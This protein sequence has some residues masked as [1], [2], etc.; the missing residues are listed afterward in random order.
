MSLFW[1]DSVALCCSNVE[2][3]KTWW[4]HT[5]DCKA[6]KVPETWDC[7]LPSDVALKLPGALDDPTILLCDKAEVQKAGYERPND[8]T[9]LFCR[10]IEKAMT[11]WT[12]RARRL[13]QS[14]TPEERG[15]LIFAILKATSSRSA[16]SRSPLEAYDR[17]RLTPCFIGCN[18]RP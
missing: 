8:H 15:T 13:D 3:E 7:P 4:I 5:F 2:V 1:T 9:V 12:P 10:R 16:K 17:K 14:K 11:T 18:L 6:V